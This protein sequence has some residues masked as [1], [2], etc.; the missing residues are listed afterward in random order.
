MSLEK[1]FY[2]NLKLFLKDLVIVFPEDDELMQFLTTSINLAII[3]DTDYEI[4]KRFYTSMGPIKDQIYNRDISI[5]TLD[6][7]LYWPMSSYEYRLFIK[8]NA[9]WNTFTP[10]NQ[11]IMWEYIQLLYTLSDKIINKR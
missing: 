11:N 10:H 9:S 3:E 5:F 1:T 4:I 7:G 2:Q 8:I 6:P